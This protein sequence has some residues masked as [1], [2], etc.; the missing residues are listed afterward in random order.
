MTAY[1]PDGYTA[2]TPRLFVADR[3]RMVTFLRDAFGATGEIIDDSPIQVWVDGALILI[4]SDS[5]RPATTSTFY[6]Y[7]ANTDAT[8]AR[9]L[10]A[11]GISLESPADQPYGDRRAMV[12]DPFGNTWQIATPIT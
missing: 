1:I 4:G 6:V 8:Y 12:E 7:V 2:V 3:A 5:V 11:G 10:A 9:A